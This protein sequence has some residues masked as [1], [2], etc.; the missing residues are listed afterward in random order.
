VTESDPIRVRRA[1]VARWNSLA[2]RIGYLLWLIA[3]IVFFVG[4][5]TSF[6]NTVSNVV[7]GCLIAGSILLVPTIIIGYAVNAA[8]RDDRARGL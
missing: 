4:Y 7:I 3:M 1:Q 8:A 6:N 2:K 5:A